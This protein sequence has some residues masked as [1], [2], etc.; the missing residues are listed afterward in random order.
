MGVRTLNA[1]VL[2]SST[3]PSPASG[4]SRSAD[5]GYACSECGKGRER[6]LYRCVCV[7]VWVYES[8]GGG[9]GGCI[10]LWSDMCAH[11][12]LLR[13]E[14]QRLNV[15]D[16]GFFFVDFST[17]LFCFVD[18]PFFFSSLAPVCLPRCV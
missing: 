2:A 5:A 16:F 6:G 1:A 7:W 9:G 15:G 11:I 18:E 8:G 14:T 10:G 17:F 12:V 13:R 3:S 4:N